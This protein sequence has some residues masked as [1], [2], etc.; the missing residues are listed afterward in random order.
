MMVQELR[1]TTLFGQVAVEDLKRWSDGASL[2]S[3]DYEAGALVASRGDPCDQLLA[4][5]A[6]SLDASMVDYA[7]RQLTI[8]TLRA[9]TIVAGSILFATEA[10]LPVQLVS[11]DRARLILVPRAAILDLCRRSREFLSCLLRDAGDRVTFLADKIRFLQMQTLR[12][13]VAAYLLDLSVSQSADLLRVPYSV[14]RLAEVFGVARPSLSR[15]ISE[16]VDSGL[17]ARAGRGL[18]ITD[19][20]AL[21]ELQAE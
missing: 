21:E 19:R 9:P 6:G 5:V 15:A 2:A 11:V 17:I 12:Q 4:L 20:A 10:V 1:R 13:K 18:R 7:G 8:E 3:R 14:E 16:L